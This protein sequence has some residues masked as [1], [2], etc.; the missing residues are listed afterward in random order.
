MDYSLRMQK[1]AYR[2]T[3]LMLFSKPEFFSE[4]RVECAGLSFPN[5]TEIKPEEHDQFLSIRPT[6]N[7]SLRALGHFQQFGKPLMR[8]K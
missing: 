5:Y 7:L 1:A 3:D 8:L 6:K 4:I 2:V